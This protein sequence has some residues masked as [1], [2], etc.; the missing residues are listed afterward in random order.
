[1][2]FITPIH[3]KTS[4]KPEQEAIARVLKLGWVAQAKIN[5]RR[6]QLHVSS[7]GKI[8]AYNRQGNRHTLTLPL[9]LR[10]RILTV[11]K[12]D[13]GVN[14]FDCEWYTPTQQIFLFD[15]IALED[16]VFSMKTYEER[17]EL[18]VKFADWG[19][20]KDTCL[21]LLPW[22]TD[23]DEAM[24]IIHMDDEIIE[25]L[26]FKARNSK[27]FQNTSVIRCR[28]EGI[29]FLHTKDRIRKHMELRLV[30]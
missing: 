29:D 2:R 3:P 26:V 19:S 12:P 28:R 8:I 25:G 11:C 1:M 20:F 5:G 15:L 18:L 4:I 16:K 10:N 22:I 23:I 7:C 30:R 13:T 14:V 9:K 6:L 21:V 17:F 27:G 24:G